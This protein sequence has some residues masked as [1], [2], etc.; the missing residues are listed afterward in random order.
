MTDVCGCCEPGAPATPLRV[1]NRPALAAIAYRIGTFASFRHAMLQEI[2]RTPELASLGTR[3]SQDYVITFFELWAAVADILTFYQERY[4]NE[5][6]LRTSQ[7][8]ESVGRLARLLD[9]H[10]GPGAAALTYLAFTVEKGK[11]V[12]V[13]VGLRVQSVPG[14]DE[15]PQVFETL[16]AMVADARFNRLR[17]YPQPQSAPGPLAQNQMTAILDRIAGPS[18]AAAL[19]PGDRVV[20]FKD[21]MTTPPEEKEVAAVQ[22]EDDRAVVTWTQPVENAGWDSSAMA[23]KFR[24]TFRLFGHNAPE[25]HMTADTPD[26][27]H[28]TR[29]RWTLSTLTSA[30]YRFPHGGA[31]SAAIVLDG[32]YEGLEV[33]QRVLVVDTDSAGTKTLVTIQKI[34]QAQRTLGSLS[35]TITRLTITPSI[36]AI[37]DRR[38]AL[39]YELLGPQIQFWSSRYDAALST[40]VVY[41]PGLKVQDDQGEGVEVGRTIERHRFQPGV[42]LRPVEF[43]IGRPVLLVDAAGTPALTKIKVAPTLEPAGASPGSFCH[44]VVTLDLPGPISLKTASAVLLGNIA[45]ASHGETVRNE[46]VG[47]TDAAQTFQRFTLARKPLTYL[48]SATPEGLS[49]T[50][51]L[52]VNGIRWT[53]VPGLFGQPPTSR[54]YALRTQDDGTS[55]VQFGDGEAGAIPPTGRANVTATYR[56]GLGLAGRVRAGQ[57]TAALDRPPGLAAVTNPLPG[58]G[59]ADPETRD[60]ARQNAPR[61]VRT[62]G[63]AV[64]LRDFEDLVTASGEVAKAQATWVWDG[65]DRAIFLTAAGQRGDVFSD[66]GLRRVADALDAV[67]DPHHRLRLDNFTRVAITLTATLR[68]DPAYVRTKVIDAA[69]AALLDALSFDRLALG[70]SIHLS[71]IY[72]ILQDVPGVESADIDHLMFKQPLGMS[73]PDF[74]IFLD[75]RAITRLPD[76]SSDPVQ[77]HLRIF[78]ARPDPAGPGTVLPAEMAEIASPTQDVTLTGTGGLEA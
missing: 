71:D 67:R 4:V 23:Y 26:P 75:G 8:R 14:Q 69:R 21:G 63:R 44:L 11:T 16:S 5:A 18:M 22:V 52:K 50:L 55:Q 39:I 43:E 10:L 1:E 62:F 36:P 45:L 57:L 65:L 58:E 74:Q 27:A 9:Y 48:A 54:V 60:A 68:I 49:S 78:G 29:I 20:L 17:I 73:S 56:V 64:S 19:A 70:Q 6:F 35:D 76:G 61:T 66:D 42:V 40:D 38:D 77:G 2:A 15:T 41:L 46:T 24:R 32:R 30:D 33:G 31:T 37:A 28:P 47:S 25:Q 13:P 53:E 34:T 12:Q 51:M 3:Q 72:R 59:G 7:Q